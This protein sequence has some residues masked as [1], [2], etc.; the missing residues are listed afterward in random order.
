MIIFGGFDGQKKTFTLN[1]VHSYAPGLYP[2][3]QSFYT[4][5]ARQLRQCATSYFFADRSAWKDLVPSKSR[6]QSLPNDR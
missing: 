4:F 1:Q 5:V 3:F 2:P 6:A